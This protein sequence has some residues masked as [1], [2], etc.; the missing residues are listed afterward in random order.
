MKNKN[1]KSCLQ[2]KGLHTP[3]RIFAPEKS[4]RNSTGIRVEIR[5]P[6]HTEAKKIRDLNVKKN[7][8]FLTAVGVTSH[9]I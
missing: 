5:L 6:G 9:I 1:T 8:F 2:F 7:H 4:T 3:T